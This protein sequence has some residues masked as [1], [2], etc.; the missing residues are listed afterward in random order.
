MCVQVSDRESDRL[1]EERGIKDHNLT[2]IHQPLHIPICGI[3]CSNKQFHSE[4]VPLAP[5]S[6]RPPSVHYMASEIRNSDRVLYFAQRGIF[7]NLIRPIHLVLSPTKRVHGRRTA[8]RE[9]QGGQRR[10]RMNLKQLMEDVLCAN[11]NDYYYYYS[12]VMM[13][14]SGPV[15]ISY[16]SLIGSISP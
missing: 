14:S 6:P 5:R 9:A 11:N 1:V 16:S 3:F 8:S 4:P 13:R 2:T 12:S 15:P 10:L 7:G